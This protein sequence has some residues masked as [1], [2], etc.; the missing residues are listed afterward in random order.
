MTDDNKTTPR[1]KRRASVKQDDW[2]AAPILVTPEQAFVAER[3]SLTR[4][5]VAIMGDVYRE[6]YRI[7]QAR[8][9]RQLDAVLAVT[10]PLPPRQDEP[11]R[12]APANAAVAKA[13]VLKDVKAE[14]R[15]LHELGGLAGR[16]H[17]KIATDMV[18]F[19]KDRFGDTL[20]FRPSTSKHMATLN[21]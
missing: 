18:E 15:R 1:R 20:D 21:S 11:A 7:K 4:G 3:E 17:R 13:A 16:S 14:L 12:A 10:E 9:R 19:T 2:V 8:I 6:G 5:V